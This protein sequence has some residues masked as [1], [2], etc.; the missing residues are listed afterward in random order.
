MWNPL[1]TVIIPTYNRRKWIGECLD[2]IEAQ[3]YPHVETLIIDDCSNDGTIEWLRSEPRYAFA[4][5][6]VQERNGGASEARNVGIRMARGELIAFIDSDDVLA[7]EHLE[8]AVEI[9]RQHSNVGLFCCDSTLIGPDGELLYEGRTWH[10]IQSDIKHYAVKSGRRDLRDIF[11]FSNCFPGFTLRRE[12]FDHI[13]FFDQGIFPLD[14]YDLALRVA[15]S[16]YA[17]YYY[18][19][20]LCLRREHL[21]QCSGAANAIRVGHETIRALRLAL[22]RNPELYAAMGHSAVRRRLAAIRLE[23][24]VSR[25]YAGDRTGGLKTMMQAVASDPQQLLQVVRLGGRR[26]QRLMA[27]N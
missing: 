19:Q 7:P 25:I 18:H 12:V 23:M 13:G 8:T 16:D 17:V 24:A 3:S 11:L 22:Q 1:V 27:S 9:F 6:H 21:G 14:D 5:S 2:S 15:G 10:Q 4:Q 20:P 26:M